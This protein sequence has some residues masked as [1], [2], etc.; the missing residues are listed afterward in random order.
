MTW[1]AGVAVVA[2]VLLCAGERAVWVWYF[3]TGWPLDGVRRTDATWFRRGQRIYV[4]DPQGR[5]PG[6]W[7]RLSRLERVAARFAG[8][9]MVAAW[10]TAYVRDPQGTTDTLAEAAVMVA[11]AGAPFVGYGLTEF[12]INFPH[13]RRWV[14]PL[15]VALTR[16]MGLPDQTRPRQYLA[17]PRDFENGGSSIVIRLPADFVSGGLSGG[18]RS[19][20]LAELMGGD[21]DLIGGGHKAMITRALLD[22]LPLSG[23]QFVW[24]LQGKDH[25]LEIRPT[26]RPPDR[27]LITH[28]PVR[29]MV[30]GLPEG[31]LLV[32]LT[33]LPLGDRSKL[34]ALAVAAGG[35]PVTVDLAVESPHLGAFGT[36]GSGKSVL[37]AAHAAQVLHNGGYVVFIDIKRTSHKWAR[38]LPGV[39]YLETIPEIS[40]ALVELWQEADRRNT[41]MAEWDDDDG[42]EPD[43]GPRYFIV[44]EE[45]NATFRKIGRHWRTVRGKDDPKES[46]AVTAFEDLI[47]TGRAGK[48]NVFISGQSGTTR[49]M[50]GPE[51]RENLQGAKFLNRW[52][53]NAWRMLAPEVSPAPRP[54]RHTGRWQMVRAGTATEVQVLFFSDPKYGH[55][56]SELRQWATSGLHPGEDALPEIIGAGDG[57]PAPALRP[58]RPAVTESHATDDVSQQGDEPVT[59]TGRHLAIV[60]DTDPDEEISLRDAVNRGVIGPTLAAV[61]Q[62][63]QRNRRYFPNPVKKDGQTD[64]FSLKELQRYHANRQSAGETG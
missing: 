62:D 30:M 40:Q 52:S 55:S 43:I 18:G 10:V 23:S 59:V 54:T 51:I 33:A 22:K 5:Y 50:G 16:V 6:A 57:M 64:L 44:F 46:P 34:P 48:M 14:W 25:H 35:M 29:E 7:H 38:G 19:G 8:V 47:F 41:I 13:R 58:A 26:P 24:H 15:H 53:L 9:G 61:R 1:L 27:V 3:V 56:A 63:R 39:I 37:V 60:Q 12:L 11:I 42:P 45:V 17:V 4:P 32:G 36:T 21:P 49:S 20:M 31:E 2:V 28:T